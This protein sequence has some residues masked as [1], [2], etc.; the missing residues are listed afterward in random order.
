MRWIEATFQEPFLVLAAEC[1]SCV[2]LHTIQ[3]RVFHFH[4]LGC[5]AMT[6]LSD[7]ALIRPLESVSKSVKK[8]DGISATIGCCYLKSHWAEITSNF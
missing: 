5:L 7:P 6:W 1:K 2:A 8:R 3:N 4:L